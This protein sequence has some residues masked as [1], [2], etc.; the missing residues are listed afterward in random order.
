MRFICLFLF[1][2]VASVLNINA[3]EK[4]T[5]LNEL[6]EVTIEKNPQIRAAE[7][8]WDASTK[9]PSQEGSLPDPVIGVSWANVSFDGITLNEEPMS[10]L[11]F[12]FSQEFPFPGK[13]SLRE[14]IAR[15]SAGA[16]KKNYEASVRS[17]VADLKEAYYD[18]F[19]IHRS[20]DITVNNKELLEK[21]TDISTSRYEVGE[22]I[23][24]DV[25]RA[26]LEV[27]RFMEQ[28]EILKQRKGIAEARIRKIANLDTNHQLGK[29]ETIERSVLNYTLEDLYRITEEKAPLLRAAGKIIDRQERSLELAERQYYPD[30]M[31]EVAPGIMGKG[32]GGIQGRWEVALGVRVPLY[33]WRKQ[34]FGVEEAAS[35]LA[36]A[37]HDYTG[38]KQDHI[39]VIKDNYLQAKTAENLLSLFEEGLIPQATLS[40][41]SAVSSYRAGDIDFLT[42][43]E[44]LITLYSL[45]VNYY[46]YLT[47][48]ETALAR[49][50]EVAPVRLGKTGKDGRR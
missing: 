10:M 30:F 7:A 17:V 13:L 42:L 38:V 35:E 9:R 23:M 31:V 24:Q 11:M 47:N 46:T 3:G 8:R 34:R 40:L 14:E 39:F 26:Q 25:I 5:T 20:L 45:E 6:V 43:L 28:I 33:F 1:L 37:K 44:S 50:E 18:W 32:D 16:Q 21:F 49:I 12:P 19:N 36:A 4:V 48:H 2:L 15:E 22:G 41:E 27:S 29:P